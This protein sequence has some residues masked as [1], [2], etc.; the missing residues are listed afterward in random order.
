MVNTAAGNTNAAHNWLSGR[1]QA[2]TASPSVTTKSGKATAQTST[3]RI[4]SPY[5]DVH[6]AAVADHTYL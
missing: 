2:K 5:W 4:A 3:V 1:C 6:Q